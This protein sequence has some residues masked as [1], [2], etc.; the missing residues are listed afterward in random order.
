[1]RTEIVNARYKMKFVYYVYD[2]GRIFSPRTNRFMSTSLDKYGYEKVALISDDNKR[3]R[4]SVH[5]IVLENFNPVEGMDKLQVNHKDGNKRNNRLEN[6]EWT[7]PSENIKHAFK[8]GLKTQVGESN[9]AC[10]YSEQ[11]ILEV[12]ELLKTGKYT[13]KELDE[14]FGFPNNYANSI[15]RGE[16]WSYLTKDIVF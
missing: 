1:M 11:T 8:I 6:L 10:K 12:I 16:R 13:G 15:R 4:Y 2:D 9:N 3:H 14:M 7:T 5:R